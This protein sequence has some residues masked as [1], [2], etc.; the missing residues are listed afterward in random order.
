MTQSPVALDSPRPV[1][2]EASA[3]TGKTY[4]SE[5]LVVRLV[6][7]RAVP[8][9]RLLIITFTKAATADLRRRVRARLVK[10]R[11]AL[12]SGVA[13]GDDETVAGLL[14]GSAGER[15]ARLANLEGALRDFD[16][17]AISTIHG[18]C[19]RTLEELA[20]AADQ[21]PGLEVL[22]EAAALRDQIL[23]DE[24]ANAYAAAQPE[25][26]GLF[27]DLGWTED[28]LKTLVKQLTGPVCPRVEPGLKGPALDLLA[29]TTRWRSA[30]DGFAAWLG[31]PDGVA[32][33]G[34]LEAAGDRPK[35]KRL[36]VGVTGN[37]I[38]SAAA[39]LRAWVDAGGPRNTGEP[40]GHKLDAKWRLAFWDSKKVPGTPDTQPGRE[41][42]V[43]YDALR[44]LQ[45]ELWP[46]PL[47]EFAGRVRDV[48]QR[49]LER[50]GLL[51][52]DAMLS[53]L[54]DRLTD[55]GPDGVLANAIRTRYDA[56][57]V[58]EFQDT[59][60]A[61][62]GI[63]RTVFVSAQI[64]GPGDTT[65]R[66]FFAVGDPKQS[67]YGF[68]NADI[69]VYLEAAGRCVIERL[70]RNYRSDEPLV[71]ALNHVWL[72]AR[73]DNNVF[74]VDSIRYQRVSAERPSRITNAP[75]VGDRERQPLE[76]RWFDGEAIGEAASVLPSKPSAQQLVARLCA[77]ECRDLLSAKALRVT[78]EGKA[79][80]IRPGDLAVLTRTNDQAL[81]MRAELASLGIPAVT[82]SAS[83][84]F[85][86][87]AVG[88]LL[89]WLE[90]V[91]QPNTESPARRLAV[92]P[93]VGWSAPRLA[94]ELAGV[95][96]G[97]DEQEDWDTFRRRLAAAAQTW[98]VQGFFRVFDAATTR[99]GLW[100]RLLGTA[101]GERHA[102]DLRH[103]VEILHAEERRSR[104]GPRALAEWL[105]RRMADA[106]ENDEEQAQRLESDASA[107]QLVTIHSSKGL[108]YP[109]VFLPFA[110]TVW[111]AKDGVGPKLWSPP[112]SADRILDLNNVATTHRTDVVLPAMQE[113]S[114]EDDARLLYVAMTRALH[115]VVLWTGAY[116]GSEA[117][118]TGRL[119]FP[120]DTTIR[121]LKKNKPAWT[122]D[123]AA[124]QIAGV[125]AALDVL[126]ADV[127]KG[128][129]W[130][131]VDPPGE[132]GEP[133]T[134]R[135]GQGA[136]DAELPEAPR[137]WSAER[138]LGAGWMVASYSSMAGGKGIDL[139][140]PVWRID[141]ELEQGPSGDAPLVGVGARVVGW[142]QLSQN[143]SLSAA[144][145]AHDLPGGADCGNWLHA[146]F[147]HLQFSGADAGKA[148]DGRSLEELV[149]EEGL[150]NGV[151][152]P[153]AHARVLELVPGWL[154]TPLDGGSRI[155][156][157][158]T[159]GAL[160]SAHR[161]DELEFD[162]GLGVGTGRMPEGIV[163]G[164][165]GRIRGGASRLALRSALAD[166]NFGGGDWLREVLA[167]KKPD[168]S[169]RSPLP[170][171]A[172]V[173]N[174]FIDLTFRTG[175]AGADGVYWVA[176]YKSNQVR[177]PEAVQD[178]HR[179]LADGSD[180]PGPRLRGLHYTRPLLSWAMA[181]SAYHLQALLYTVAL[182]RLLKQRLGE[183]VYRYNK[184][185]GGHLYLFLRGMGG[186]K[187]LR[188]EGG[189][190]LGVWADR[191]PR[192]T[193]E[194]LDCALNGGSEADVQGVLDDVGSES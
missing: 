38:R 128:I 127:K 172:G 64:S 65:G 55:Q 158:F 156:Q 153:A 179:A 126:C 102:T 85:A 63:L 112:G 97:R 114:I 120:P 101:A 78:V 135:P 170:P 110:W 93:L 91:A 96:S 11:D 82:A 113:R 164:R 106:D 132:R 90:A 111:T 9:D 44:D 117:S 115:H 151:V 175:G 173:L 157:G 155:P 3:G 2:I 145:A 52:Y 30:L 191:W 8:I 4:R 181:H 15:Q 133:W 41:V 40:R 5:G 57:I 144:A 160:D 167:R 166:P 28:N 140:E 188:P 103:V 104:R 169:P 134:P 163:D 67:I 88:W 17:A 29:I 42:Y 58:D 74:A 80:E 32:A 177:G 150:R 21:E 16:R 73:P 159:L 186:A 86:S 142:E 192:A 23:A 143:A 116:N 123:D 136:D 20:F 184:H 131:A 185:V 13:P 31:G 94:N 48:Y 46:Q 146:V 37:K 178:W 139:D 89:A 121:R 26:V 122:D 84:V 10:A 6:A 95:A 53:R 72:D 61:Q 54:A 180:E 22:G 27:G 12:R 138:R 49:E 66:R 174:G 118:A 68:R 194:A 105:R 62:W 108:Q 165:T 152:D 77:Q 148:R 190:C 47:I 99:W 59:D 193:V 7:E 39:K 107:V 137:T 24:W 56:A 76:I 129:G 98:P 36:L 100:P 34:A 149:A 33:M 43:R 87:Q 18:F 14:K 183:D 161:L 81:L 182:H 60:A 162:L 187:T 35:G 92:T 189:A 147:E 70:D 45:D 75:A 25:D 176:D 171:I 71:T 83:S 79:S 130:C 51:T 125:H 1:L 50:L 119:L 154:A 19:Q 109:F 141:P 168:G 69:E 124:A